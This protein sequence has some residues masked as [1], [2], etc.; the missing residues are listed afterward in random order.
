MTGTLELQTPIQPQEASQEQLPPERQSVRRQGFI[1]QLMRFCIVG[2]L[3]TIVD[4]LVLNGLLWFWPAQNTIQLVA[5]N[6]IAYIIGAVN[7]FFWNKQWTFQHRQQASAQEVTRFALTTLAGVLCND[8][9][10]WIAGRILHPAVLS[11]TLWAN[12]SKIVAIAGT[13]LISYLG[14]RLWVFVHRPQEEQAMSLISSSQENNQPASITDTLPRSY[15]QVSR[16]MEQRTWL[17]THSLSVV[18]P[19]YNEEHVIVS[20][21]VHVLDTL[22]RWVRD[23]EVI[24]V[25]DGSKDRTGALVA[26]MAASDSRIRLVTHEVNQGYG[27]TLADGFAVA[28]KELTFFMDSDGQ[29]DIHDLFNLFPFIDEYDAVIGYRVNRQDALIRKMNAWGWKSLVGFVLDV[30][31]R[32]IDC[33]FKL[34]RTDFLQHYPLETRGAMLNAELL[35][36]LKQ[37]GCSYRE[38]GVHHLPRQGGRA[39]GANIRVIARAFR[40]LFV[41]QRQWRQGQ[42]GQ[43]GR[44]TV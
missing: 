13:V 7:S 11:A 35:Y 9:L 16:Q 42:Q 33:A 6:S 10:L 20:T 17:T 23:F 19:A 37:A 1:R 2:G 14:M 40:E 39:T 31:V 41:Y 27:A 34:L 29:F 43:Q 21:L 25:N 4:L 18:L 8:V 36:K 30:H 38:V 26:S 15:R 24:V 28:S 44:Q 3:N 32:D 22:D 12:I 5:Y